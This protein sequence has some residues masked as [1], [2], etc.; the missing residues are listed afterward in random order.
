[1]IQSELPDTDIRI[2]FADALNRYD[3]E[4]GSAATVWSPREILA[5]IVS[6]AE[7]PI[8]ATI[9]FFLRPARPILALTFRDDLSAGLAWSRHL[10][11]ATRIRPSLTGERRYLDEG[12]ITWHG[13]TV[14]I[15]AS[16]PI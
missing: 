6:T 3:D 1:M 11:G 10:G 12:A 2:A 13:W 15:T 4:P 9:F 5:E 16:E 8:P 7:L 14:Q